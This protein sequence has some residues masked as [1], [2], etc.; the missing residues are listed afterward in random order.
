MVILKMKS[1]E[2][3]RIRTKIC[4]WGMSSRRTWTWI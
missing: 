4:I 2:R 3:G 1:S